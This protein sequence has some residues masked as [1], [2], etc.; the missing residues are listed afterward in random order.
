MATKE[1]MEFGAKQAVEN[2]TRV[3]KGEKVVIITDRETEKIAN[4]VAAAVENV[5][6]ILNK[7]IM[8]DL[9][10]RPVDGS[11]P[12]KFPKEIE[13]A[14]R[15]SEV[16]FYIAQDAKGELT[17]FR[18]PL[19]KLIMSIPIRH[20]H[21]ISINEKMMEQGMAADYNEIHRLNET[22]YNIVTKAKTIHITTLAGT[23]VTLQFNPK[24]K[25]LKPDGFITEDMWDN[26]P[27][28]E[29]LTYPENAN[30]KVVVDAVFG[31]FFSN[32]YGDVQKNPLTYEIK[33]SR[34]I[35]D[36]VRCN[37]EELKNEF[38]EY[39][40]NGEKNADRVGELGI[41]TNLGVKEIIG[42]L[43]QDEK[44]PGAHIALGDAFG[45]MTGAPYTCGT[46][47]DGVMRNPTIDV[48]GKIIMK[49]GKFLV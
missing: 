46:H 1:Q 37:N 20:G 12:L 45:P 43:L 8:E 5:G 7:F 15:S 2:C 40:F 31:D 36:S 26:L 33:D 11:N 19:L 14:M 13:D 41:G 9:G 23:D 29:V 39:I 27:A 34:A 3:K 48:E 10:D 42:N 28:G 38:I 17:T 18:T 22:I 47:L 16:S 44:F 25:W 21:M 4:Y 49:N 24:Y 35:K 6:G 30:G 32:K